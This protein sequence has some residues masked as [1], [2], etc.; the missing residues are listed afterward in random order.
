MKSNYL[1]KPLMLLAAFVLLLASCSKE[2]DCAVK[3]TAEDIQ[4]VHHYN[5]YYDFFHLIESFDFEAMQQISL[6][7]DLGSDANNAIRYRIDFPEGY[8]DSEGNVWKGGIDYQSRMLAPNAAGN[9]I[10]FSFDNLEFNGISV[11]GAKKMSFAS[12]TNIDWCQYGSPVS[13]TMGDQSSSFGGCL[14]K[15]LSDS[16]MQVSGSNTMTV[17]GKEY[18]LEIS[19][20]MIKS[21]NCAWFNAGELSIGSESKTSI[22]EFKQ[23]CAVPKM[24]L[25]N[26]ERCHV[27]ELEEKHRLW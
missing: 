24:T 17:N 19:E 3:I 6:L 18:I 27:E 16:Q 7:Q 9:E 1:L 8:V 5:A 4:V 23:E 10:V 20:S 25:S 13:F 21:D 12:A 15:V 22:L 2:D 14:T 26:V 11:G